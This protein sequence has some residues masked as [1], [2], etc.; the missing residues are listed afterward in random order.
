MNILIVTSISPPD[1]GGPAT[2]CWQLARALSNKHKVGV[3]TFTKNPK[4][5]K[6]IK[7][8]SVKVTGGTIGRQWCLLKAIIK[9][10]KTADVIYAQDPLVVGM[11]S[12]VAGLMTGKPLVIKFVGDIVWESARNEGRF[13][14]TLE[15]FYQSKLSVIDSFKIWLQ[16]IILITAHQVVVPSRYLK[17][18][19]VKNFAVSSQKIR[20]I[21]NGVIITNRRV[22]NKDPRLVLTAA[23]LV[24]WKK[25]KGIIKAIKDFPEL[26]YKI[27]GD[28]PEKK[29]LDRLVSKSG[30]EKQVKLLG[31]KSQTEVKRIMSRSSFFILNSA[32]EG[33]PHVLLEAASYQNIII[34]PDL[35][36][37]REVF[38]EKE[39][40]L[41][42]PQ[43][44]KLKYVLEQAMTEK[45]ASKRKVDQAYKKVQKVFYWENTFSQTEQLLQAIIEGKR[46]GKMV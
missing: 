40:W 26:N 28:G 22:F 17:R 45:K 2:Y 18:F 30:L 36:G 31:T 10:A 21:Y 16:K 24:S 1:I 37:I 7:I 20:V 13:T 19:L 39:A 5:E 8:V 44:Q 27:I 35:P 32:Y 23:R 15:E 46:L 6:Q 12:S 4:T 3:I 41:F 9:L 33:L 29:K 42:E 11:A 14:G 38:S 43:R 34:A 25:I